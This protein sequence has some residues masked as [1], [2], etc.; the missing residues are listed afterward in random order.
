MVVDHLSR[1]EYLK[2]YLVPIND[3]FTYDR[4]IAIVKTNHSDDPDLYL[5]LNIENALAVTNVPWYANFVNYI[6]ADI[7]PHNLNYQ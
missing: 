1:L 3:D 7:I 6:V 2:P 4:L 5:E